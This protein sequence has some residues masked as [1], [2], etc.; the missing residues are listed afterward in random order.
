V[1]RVAVLTALTA[2][3]ACAEPAVEGPGDEPPDADPVSPADTVR[4]PLQLGALPP[5]ETPVKDTLAWLVSQYP[6]ATP[7]TELA[8]VFE[9]LQTGERF[10]YH[11]A[12][13]HVSASSA[14]AWWVAAALDGTTIAAVTPYANPV[15]V[16]SDN[17]AAG[18]VIDLIGPN[19]VNTWMWDVGG[20]TNSALTQWSVDKTRV[21]TN[22]PR[23]MGSDNYMTAIDAVTFLGRVFRGEILAG[24]KG[25]QLLSWLTL[26]PNSGT[27]GWLPARLPADVAPD[28][29][30]KAGWLPPGCCSTVYNT[31][32]EIGII[33]AP[34]G[35]AFA[36]AILARKGDDY[37]NKQVPFV[38]LSACMLYRA[39][40]KDN[41][42]E[43][44]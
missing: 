37:W 31:S 7:G 2:L 22:S 26:S 9:D 24:A 28:A 20:M 44:N 5:L 21:A 8:I 30:H 29:M 3:V 15:F 33:V 14:K 16:N 18:R 13:K 10:T 23:A 38:E 11:G 35:R 36:L 32:N 39:F 4:E 12:T 27:G 40:A 19:A 1:I 25:D 41:A 34:D 6:T 17:S 43:C 42:L